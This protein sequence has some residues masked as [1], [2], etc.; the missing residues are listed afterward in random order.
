MRKLNEQYHIQD[1]ILKERLDQVLG[2]VMEECGIECWLFA[3]RE[4][5]EDPIF[6][7]ITPALYPTARRLTILV[8]ARKD[9]KT[10]CLNLGMPD[11]FLNQ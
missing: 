1:Q 2:E 5:N 4:Y 9:G 11:P 8:F 7:C 10:E 6:R 3:C